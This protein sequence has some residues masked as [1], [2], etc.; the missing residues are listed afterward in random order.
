MII[1]KENN[2]IMSLIFFVV[3]FSFIMDV[4]AI[5]TNVYISPSLEKVSFA[6]VLIYFKATISLIMLI[7]LAYWRRSK[8]FKLAIQ[9]VQMFL[10]SLFVVLIFYFL[11]LYIYKFFL[12]EETIS[13]IKD[14]ILNGNPALAFEYSREN[15]RTLN[16]IFA[17]YISTNSE[18]MLFFQAL[19]MTLVIYKSKDLIHVHEDEHH[20]DEF[21]FS[22]VDLPAS[23][24]VLILSFLSLRI[25]E[26]QYDVSDLLELIISI[27]GFVFAIPLFISTLRIA[28]ISDTQTCT[29]TFFRTHHTTTMLSALAVCAISITLFIYHI[30]SIPIAGFNYRIVTT[31]AGAIVSIYLI[32]RSRYVL[33]LENK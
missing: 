6:E 9:V 17:I 1:S 8:Y 5:I 31:I 18:L 24:V 20:Y 33:S 3:L 7:L 15:L 10:I 27:A 25:L 16:Y 29:K 28:L 30:S 23:L 14:R 26:V 4:I 12:L 19:F 22:H 11:Y 2:K 32:I 13:I 21:L